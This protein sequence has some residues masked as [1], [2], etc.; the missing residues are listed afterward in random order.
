MHYAFALAPCIQT[1]CPCAGEIVTEDQKG[2]LIKMVPERDGHRLELQW[3]VPPESQAYEIF[4]CSYLRFEPI[5]GTAPAFDEVV[6]WVAVIPR[7]FAIQ[8]AEQHVP[9]CRLSCY[10]WYQANGYLYC[11]VVCSCLLG[12]EGS[13]LAASPCCQEN[14]QQIPR[15]L[16]LG[17]CCAVQPLTGA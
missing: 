8:E 12:Y 4:P 1:C 2:L 10:R 11:A 5:S 13:L 3:S 9:V 15:R 14:E 16:L 6:L 17:L 7:C